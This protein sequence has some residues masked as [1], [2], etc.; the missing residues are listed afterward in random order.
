MVDLSAAF[1]MVDHGLLL[2]KLK[3]LGLDEHAVQWFGSYL[4]S[5]SQTVC[6]DGSLYG[7][8]KVDCGVTQG[9]VLGPLLYVLFT[10]D[11]PD[12]VHSHEDPLQFKS[13]NMQCDSCGGLVN[14][15]DDATYIFAC[16]D[17]VEMSE[18]LTSQYNKI[19]TYM[20]SNKLVINADKTHLQ[21]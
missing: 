4:S 15:V 5:R 11:L 7:F 21:V 13:P 10:N 9:S 2:Q 17:P 18:K 3:L 1:D 8:L 20:A 12:V 19:S 16:V 6:I 14:F